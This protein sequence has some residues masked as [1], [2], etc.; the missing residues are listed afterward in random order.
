MRTLAAAH[1]LTADRLDPTFLLL[2]ANARFWARAP[3]PA[4]GWRTTF[5]RDPA[6]FQYYPGRGLQLQPLAC[7]GRANAIAGA[8][9]AALR[10]RTRKDRCRPA[11][12]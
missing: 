1:T 3:L 11:R 10:T 5:G 2:H 4:S 9:L 6:I 8:C 12:C 7:W